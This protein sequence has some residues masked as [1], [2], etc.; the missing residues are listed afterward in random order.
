M[1]LKFL[2][3][4]S[5]S[6]NVFALEIAPN[7]LDLRSLTLLVSQELKKNILLSIDL[8]NINVDIYFP[9]DIKDDVLFDFYKKAIE[10]K[11][12][13]L[14]DYNGY[15]VIE[16]QKKKIEKK[17]IID[18]NIQLDITVIELDNDK[19]KELGMDTSVNASANS[20]YSIGDRFNNTNIFGTG[21]LFGLKSDLKALE[22]NGIIDIT[23]N[24]SILIKNNQST[25]MIIGDTVS[26][27]TSSSSDDTQDTNIR[28]TYEQKD[29]GL[30]IS[31]TPRIR[32]D[33]RIDVNVILNME[34]LKDY[35]DGLIS[36]T[37]RSINSN[38]TID[39]GTSI[40]LGGLEQNLNLKSVHKLPLLGDIPYLRWFFMYESE[41]TINNTLSI[42][43]KVTIL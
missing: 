26:V 23:S 42:L 38:F 2:I 13:F 43:I 10:S 20:L 4:L 35:K 40:K 21:A 7:T 17:K 37:K 25:S 6:F 12:L 8:K 33:G 29:I 22:S 15:Y 9:N 39:S 36:T 18:K 28:N 34:N 5:L 30:N 11:G 41:K 32:E 27:L 16:K 19:F 3:F 24:P 31:A 14:N 1:V